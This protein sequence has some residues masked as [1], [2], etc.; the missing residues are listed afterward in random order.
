MAKATV[1]PLTG[2]ISGSVGDV[3]FRNTRRGLVA[4]KKGIP[5]T[6]T[7]ADAV[8]VK[9]RMSE[10]QSL[11][12][13]PHEGWRPALRQLFADSHL[14]IFAAFCTPFLKFLA[15]EPF[16]WSGPV[17]EP[18]LR[19]TIRLNQL[20]FQTQIFVDWENADS[21]EMW[22]GWAGT[23]SSGT[24]VAAWAQAGAG[25]RQQTVPVYPAWAVVWPVLLPAEG[26]SV[27]DRLGWPAA[28]KIGAI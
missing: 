14:P 5:P 24:V 25:S 18:I 3:E 19:S 20:G 16:E 9:N 15:G 1:G 27:Y 28:A 22:I 21:A 4:Q 8:R 13:T 12:T 7:G 17:P 23:N 11:W 26:R 6:H 10:M 2:Y